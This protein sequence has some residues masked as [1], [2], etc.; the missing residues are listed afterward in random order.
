MLRR[1]T[2]VALL[3]A[4]AVAL[5]APAG[6]LALTV[7]VRVEGP[8]GTHFGARQPLVTP[9]TGTL[10]GDGGEVELA[11]PTALGALEAASSAGDFYY[12]LSVASFGP[13]VTQVG[14]TAGEGFSGWVYKVNGVS[15]PVGADAYVLERGDE[16]LW[17]YATF[18]DA[19]G[20]PTLDLDRVARG[21]Y[22]AYKTNDLGERSFARAVTFLLDGR[23]VASKG[24]RLCPTGHWHTLRAT[25]DGFIRSEVVAR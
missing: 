19:G 16:V 2:L 21:C 14:R 18:G 13:Y 9:F 4:L 25:K 1:T 23:A 24:G 6:A 12:H 11:E 3:S 22:R 5:A 20:P 10:A 17:Y 15:P 8:L 7:H